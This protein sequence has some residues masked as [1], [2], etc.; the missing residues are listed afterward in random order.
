[1]E[2]RLL[3]ISDL[4]EFIKLLD[5]KY[6]AK[7]TKAINAN[8]KFIETLERSKEDSSL[9][10]YGSFDE[11][12]KLLSAICQ[13]IWLRFPSYAILW[14]LIHPK[15]MNGSF[16]KSFDISGLGSS[17]DRAI[18]YGES[19]NRWQF[20]YGVTVKNFTTRRQI[21]L[22]R[23]NTF[24]ERYDAYVETVIKAGNIPEFEPWKY[25]IG[26]SARKEDIIIKTCRLKNI[27][28]L[29]KLRQKNLIND[30]IIN[31]YPSH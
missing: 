20:F 29:E 8:D 1:M 2:T 6:H 31:Q 15:F 17:I 25:I 24:S 4:E 11:N 19:M 3:T 12:G 5:R 27:Y 21:F 9:R 23:S 26:N 7:E 13:H 18:Q 16:S 30:N 28:I 10:V 22:E 14:M